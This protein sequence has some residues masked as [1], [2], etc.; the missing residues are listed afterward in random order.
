VLTLLID[1]LE[2]LCVEFI[3]RLILYFWIY[4]ETYFILLLLVLMLNLLSML[5]MLDSS[6][7]LVFTTNFFTVN[8]IF[9]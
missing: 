9:K 7:T 3:V 5:M 2:K 8:F 6:R 1:L 4:C